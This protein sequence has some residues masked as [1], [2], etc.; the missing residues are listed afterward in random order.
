MSS[1]IRQFCARVRKSGVRRKV[2]V[3][4]VAMGRERT[5]CAWD[6]G[7]DTFIFESGILDHLSERPSVLIVP[8]SSL[9]RRRKGWVM[10]VTTGNH[11][12]AAF[13]LLDGRFWRLSHVT[14]M[15]RG[16]VLMHDILCCN[17]VDDRI[18]TS[19]RDLTSKKL[20]AADAWLLGPAGFALND[21]VMGDRNEVTLEH[22]RALGQEWRIKPLVWT[23]NAM[24]V[25]LAAAKKRI[26]SKLVYYHSTRGVHFLTCPEFKRFVSLAET[27][28]SDFEA[29]LRE[30]V[31]VYEGNRYSFTRMPKFRGHH[32][33]EFFGLKRGVSLEKLI[34]ELEK[35][36]ESIVLG[37]ADEAQVRRR[38]CEIAALYESLLTGRDLADETSKTFT[39]SLYMCITG[40]VYSVAGEGSTPSFDDR[41]TALPGASFVS[42]RP[43][44]HP[45]ADDRSEVLLSNLRGLMS[46]DEIVEYA[47]VY[48]IHV[49]GEDVPLGNGVTREIVYKTNRSPLELS[50][51]E[52]RLSSSKKGYGAYMMARIGALKALGVK[53]SD[54]YKLLRRRAHRGRGPFDYYIR[55][56]CEGEPLDS[57][58]ANYFCNVDDSTVEEKEVVLGLATLMGDAAAQN[59]AMKKYD[60][61]TE[62]PLYGVGKEI[63]EFEYDIVRHM[64]VPKSVS[65]CSVRGSFGWPSLAHDDENL[66]SLSN[67]YLGYYAHAMKAYQ[68][69]HNVTMA[70]VAE[71]F[72]DGFSFR[73]HAMAWQLSVMRDKFE[74]FAP[75]LPASFG[76]DRKWRFLLWSLERQER[77]LAAFRRV[78][79]QKVDLIET[80]NAEASVPSSDDEESEIEIIDEDIR[81]NS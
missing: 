71:R 51:I 43:V 38:A 47:N 27:A 52:K 15:K 36:M 58:P 64:V 49:E 59:M 3:K 18:E 39:E 37:R 26:A 32:E 9:T 22:Y 29:G 79:F 65:T 24:R 72:F 41:R 30:L 60:P 33:I 50:L 6:V 17:V 69:Q 57:I 44:W 16:D 35:L 68:R 62:S 73:T 31:S 67:F 74:D 42:G 76:F 48:E 77:R 46:K 1:A 14:M 75:G 81:Y 25:A 66:N 45:G 28:P 12:V 54:S 4:T 21:I 7:D 53:L 78:F 34:P 8:K 23:Q 11:S 40:E 19:Q 20:C 61:K 2:E 80:G 56:R 10:T 55:A 63:Y 70:E 5:F 13:P